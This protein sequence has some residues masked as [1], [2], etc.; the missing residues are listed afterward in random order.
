MVKAILKNVAGE[1]TKRCQYV[2][3]GILLKTMWYW[4]K[5]KQT[6]Q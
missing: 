5:D 6:D 3:R 4:H 2:L 1:I